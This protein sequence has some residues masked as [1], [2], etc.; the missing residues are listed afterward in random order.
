MKT[1]YAIPA[2]NLETLQS[3]IDKLNRRARRIGVTEI[4]FTSEFSHLEHEYAM[5]ANDATTNNFWLRAGE[6]IPPALFSQKSAEAKPTGRVREWLTVTVDGEAPHYNGW[7]LIGVLEPLD[8][9]DG[10][11]NVVSAVPGYSVPIEYR[12]RVGQC[13][14]CH[15]SRRRNETFVV[16]H[17]N[18][19]TKMVGRQ[20]L[21]DFLGHAD[22]HQLAAW[23]E[24]LCELDG[25]CNDASD[26]DWMDG[27]CRVPEAWNL[28]RFLTVTAA[29]IR[30]DGWMSRTKAREISE[31]E[32]QCV[33]A[34]ADH[35]KMYLSPPA[36]QFRTRKTQEWLDEISELLDS[37]EFGEQAA[38]AIEWAKAID[39]GDNDYLYNVNLLSRAGYVTSKTAGVAASIIAAWKRAMDK[40]AE[41]SS[42]S[43]RPVSQHVGTLKKR[44]TLTVTCERIFESEGMYGVTGIHRLR[45]DSGNLLA[46]F[47]SSSA[48]WMKE[49]ETATVKLTPVEH[50]EFRGEK[51][52]KVNRLAVLA[53]K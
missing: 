26:F 12:N 53:E 36:R 40:A 13:D 7:R 48:E 42:K 43:E 44:M 18:G 16:Q 34:T 30:H 1:T 21:K 10:C 17:E 46:W 2:V 32:F 5:L 35:V 29:I 50:T 38:E 39:A 52:T 4:V 3:R 33:M 28:E 11:E 51:Q 23:A 41:L 37:P 15:T 14:H 22:P 8:T 31:T 24:I 49:G 25:L 20:C 45:D 47:A 6:P 27:G 19:S 9:D